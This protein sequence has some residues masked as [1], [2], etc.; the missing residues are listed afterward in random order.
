MR[1]LVLTLAASAALALFAAPPALAAGE[2]PGDAEVRTKFTVPASNGFEAG[3]AVEEGSAVIEIRGRRRYAAYVAPAEVTG[4]T[5]AA[6]FGRLGYVSLRFEPTGSPT[7][8]GPPTGCSGPP[9]TAAR[10][11]YV[12]TIAFHGEG[13][14]TV[15]AASRVRAEVTTSP[16]WKC[17]TKN[18]DHRRSREGE[19][20]R[21]RIGVLR[22]HS[23]DGSRR[24]IA[25]TGREPHGEY[26]SF[27]AAMVEHR[28]GMQIFRYDF[29][30]SQH[31]I[32]DF[33]YSH[34]RGVAAIRPPAPFHG[35][36]G[37]RRHGE[38]HAGELRGSLTADFLG[39]GPVR[40]CGRGWKASLSRRA[41]ED[42]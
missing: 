28:E 3:I 34:E 11:H 6:S 5:L 32:G 31:R 18:G 12:G 7:K 25:I 27:A 39:R 42:E 2:P 20:A 15:L 16:A 19:R 17:A 14:F 26:E 24:L 38:G 22:A 9:H 8:F 40:L 37:F 4:D 33:G 35:Q 10:G 1:W 41:P 36:A 30:A 23:A 13:G 29:F 21:R